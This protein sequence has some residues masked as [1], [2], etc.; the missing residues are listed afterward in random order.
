MSSVAWTY[1]PGS[2]RAMIKGVCARIA[3]RAGVPVWMPRLAF[4]IFGLAHWLVA[5]IVYFV[6]SK[7]FCAQRF[8]AFAAPPPP[9]PVHERFAALDRRLADMEAA[10]LAEEAGLRRA[11]RDLERG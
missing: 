2:T 6:M 3:E 11:F 5:L 10:T 9:N 1:Q 8:A 7:L 4:L